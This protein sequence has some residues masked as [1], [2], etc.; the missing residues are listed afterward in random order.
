MSANTKAALIAEA[1]AWR[2]LAELVGL[3]FR[4]S[5]GIPPDLL[6]PMQRRA[7]E[8]FYA[9][10]DVPQYCALSGSASFQG[11]DDTAQAVACLLMAL[12]CEDEAR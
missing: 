7:T 10:G 8:H 12:E 4:T 3:G 2:E 6:S 1:K 5:A 9:P 11:M